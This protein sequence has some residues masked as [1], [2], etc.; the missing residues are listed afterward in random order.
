MK[1]EI[2]KAYQT[3]FTASLVMPEVC[4]LSYLKLQLEVE[5]HCWIGSVLLNEELKKHNSF[6]MFKLVSLDMKCY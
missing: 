5:M 3:S 2:K 1:L 6:Q 4:G